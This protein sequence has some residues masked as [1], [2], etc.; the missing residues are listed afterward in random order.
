MLDY[1]GT[2]DTELEEDFEG[3]CIEGDDL[4]EDISGTGKMVELFN[5]IAL[6]ETGGQISVVSVAGVAYDG[7]Q[8]NMGAIA[9]AIKNLMTD[10]G[11]RTT[12]SE[13]N[14]ETI[15]IPVVLSNALNEDCDE[16]V[17]FE[18]TFDTS[19][20]DNPLAIVCPGDEG[21]P[22]VITVNN[23]FGRCDASV[24]FA[25]NVTGVPA[26]TSVTYKI[27]NDPITLP[28]VFPIG[29]TTVTA[30]AK[31][32]CKDVSC[33][34]D[35]TV[36]DAQEPEITCPVSGI[37]DVI[38]NDG[39]TYI[40]SGTSW[41]ATGT[42]NCTPDIDI[43]LTAKLTGATNSGPY[44]S[45]DG[46]VFNQGTT[47][48][49]WT[50]KD[51]AVNSEVC[52][53]E[54]EVSGAT[55]SGTINYHNNAG[56]PMQNVDIKLVSGTTEF[57][58]SPTNAGGVYSFENVCPGT[59]D[60]VITV[61]KETWGSINVTDAAQVNSWFIKKYSIEKVRFLAGDVAGNQSN[62]NSGEFWLDSEDASSIQRYFV[63]GGT[64]QYFDP[65][66]EFWH[67][68]DVINTQ[69]DLPGINNVLQITIPA[70]AATAEH[71][72]LGLVSGD[73]NRSFTPSA[74]NL[75][76]AKI[77]SKAAV[78]TGSTSLTLNQDESIQISP[79]T[80][81]ELPVRAETAMQ[82][83]AIS[84]I[85]NFPVEK[86]QIEDVF[87]KNNP[88]QPV[89]FDIVN[90]ELRIG[91]NSMEPISL[92]AGETMLTIRLQT[93]TGEMD[94]EVYRFKL[95]GDPLNELADGDFEV[96]QNASLVVNGLEMKNT[97][98]GVGITELPSD[99]LMKCYPNPFREKAKINYTLP[100]NG[101]VNIEV[102]GILGNR[103]TILSNQHQI[104]GDYLIDLEGDELVSGVYLVTLQFRS[105]EGTQI[106]R[107]VRMIKH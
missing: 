28:H 72:F 60:V 71:N 23:D 67:A 96:I 56:T 104:A 41:D 47:T 3:L 8:V 30:T 36:V 81:I 32:D 17:N 86:L 101:T 85:L 55:V 61:N 29:T 26:A 18:I 102:T 50:A 80:S 79:L 20:P 38:M 98:V 77:L 90:G 35:V 13:L 65:E 88:E 74:N 103:I 59:Y 19:I 69:Q 52:S 99:L 64:S 5:Q 105:Q 107:T 11:N 100:E 93:L 9:A 16:T 87:L 97:T 106:V 48:V 44:T 70:G 94:N 68:P 15:I 14:G 53:F 24:T 40:H 37:Q 66:W 7:T 10:N 2:V 22:G 1:V 57:I 84:M 34:F 78:A 76:S 75:S 43:A 51:G 62:L 54:V 89:M 46:V 49:T 95:S 4:I 42:D 73:F 58:T 82:V 92:A 91:W 31:N 33:E 27:G 6:L 21:T 39:C 45:L 83:G 25:A 63:T 12:V